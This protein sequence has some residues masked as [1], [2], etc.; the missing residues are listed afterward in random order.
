[1][2]VS[3]RTQ[4]F[5]DVE[6]LQARCSGLQQYIL[7]KYVLVKGRGLDLDCVTNC[8]TNT[9]LAM[10]ARVKAGSSAERRD[11]PKVS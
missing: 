2:L 11:V 7:Q 1:M 10:C 3:A 9:N 8:E 6:K 4:D 5:L